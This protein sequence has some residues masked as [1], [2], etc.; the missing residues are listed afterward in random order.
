MGNSTSRAIV[1][2]PLPGVPWI[3]TRRSYKAAALA[4]RKCSIGA[5][6]PSGI[7]PRVPAGSLTLSWKRAP[8]YSCQW[9]CFRR[10]RGRMGERR[11]HL[12]SRP[13]GGQASC[14]VCCAREST[15][16]HTRQILVSRPRL[17]YGSNRF[18][19]PCHSTHP[20]G[21]RMPGRWRRLWVSFGAAARS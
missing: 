5:G 17:L 18:L 19:R 6:G 16:R 10:N 7:K 4:L 8:Y 12:G 3:K 13:R 21:R 20:S 9:R 2:L 14:S 11:Y 15:A 1:V